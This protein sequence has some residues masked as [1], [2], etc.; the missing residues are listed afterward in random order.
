MWKV[1]NYLR[2]LKLNIHKSQNNFVKNKVILI[3][4]RKVA[5]PDVVDGL[6]R[7]KNVV[8]PWDLVEGN[9]IDSLAPDIIVPGQVDGGAAGLGR[10]KGQKAVR[11]G[12]EFLA[13]RLAS[14]VY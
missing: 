5:L 2:I 7:S 14:F 6:G 8:E 1:Y 10:K 4:G 13:G 12:V 3:L 9:R 11:V